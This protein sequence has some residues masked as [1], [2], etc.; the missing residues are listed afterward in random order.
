MK[1]M[2]SGFSKRK[3]KRENNSILSTFSTF[4]KPFD[5][6]LF[7]GVLLY[8]NHEI[9]M[10]SNTNNGKSHKLCSVIILNTSN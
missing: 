3:N 2:I 6:C 1:E 4:L 7:K 5:K 8:K 10:E 9:Q